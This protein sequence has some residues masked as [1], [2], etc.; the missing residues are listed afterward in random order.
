MSLVAG[1][2]SLQLPIFATQSDSQPSPLRP[3][4]HY[5]KKRS[6]HEWEIEKLGVALPGTSRASM[7][8]ACQSASRGG[9][10]DNR[11]KA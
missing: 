8:K 9:D 5:D 11:K 4:W 7:E 6:S 2:G 1:V 3:R 10:E